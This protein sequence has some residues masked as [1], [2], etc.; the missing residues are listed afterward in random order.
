MSYPE[1]NCCNHTVYHCL[2]ENA[3]IQYKINIICKICEK[4][5]A[6]KIVCRDDNEYKDYLLKLQIND[7]N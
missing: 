7:K 2:H 1:N 6:R 4:Q 5:Y 3:E